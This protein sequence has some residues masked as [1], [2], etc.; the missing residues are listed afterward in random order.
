MGNSSFP[1][2]SVLWISIPQTLTDMAHQSLTPYG[3]P[4]PDRYHH[5]LAIRGVSFYLQLG[6]R[7]PKGD[8]SCCFISGDGNPIFRSDEWE[9][10][11]AKD[12]SR[13]M[14]DNPGLTRE[15]LVFKERQSDRKRN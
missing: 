3:G 15:F 5:R 1:G 2:N 9:A 10:A 11:M 4:G 8:K 6:S 12:F 7:I 14:R 13:K